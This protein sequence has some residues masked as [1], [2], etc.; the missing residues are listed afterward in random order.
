MKA[1]YK[2]EISIPRV[3]PHDTKIQLPKDSQILT[4][5]IQG[6][7]IVIY[8]WVDVQVEPY[9]A[10]CSIRLIGTGNQLPGGYLNCYKHL[11]TLMVNPLWVIH[12]FIQ[13]DMIL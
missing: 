7:N 4:A 2:Y 12:I 6:N 9:G 8:A 3:L 10:E 11:R 1:I 13:D 5:E